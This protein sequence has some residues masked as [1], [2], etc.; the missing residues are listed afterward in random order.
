MDT[1]DHKTHQEGEAPNEEAQKY[2]LFYGRSIKRNR[3]ILM[4][5]HILSVFITGIT[6]HS[7][8]DSTLSTY[9]VDNAFIDLLTVII[10]VAVSLAI[11]RG[12][13]DQW[14]LFFRQ[15]I[16]GY[17]EGTY[18]AMYRSTLIKL[19]FFSALNPLTVFIGSVNVSDQIT[20]EFDGYN[21]RELAAEYREKKEAQDS[22]GQIKV[23]QIEA[24][25][26]RAKSRVESKYNAQIIA[27]EQE[28]ARWD[29]LEKIRNRTYLSLKTKAM[30]KAQAAESEKQAELAEL[31]G[32]MLSKREEV[33]AQVEEA[34]D[35]LEAEFEH[36]DKQLLTA[37]G[38]DESRHNATG[39]AITALTIL[40][41]FF[42][43]AV[44]IS[45]GYELELYYHRTEQELFSQLVKPSSGNGE[46]IFR[47]LQQQVD[48]R[49]YNFG[50]LVESLV[51]DKKD[52]E[53]Y[54]N[55]KTIFGIF[56]GRAARR[57]E[58]A[59]RAIKGLQEL[60][61][62]ERP[63]ESPEGLN[64]G[65]A[66]EHERLKLE[67]EQARQANG[68]SDGR[69]LSRSAQPSATAVERP[70]AV[71]I[72]Y[73]EGKVEKIGTEEYL[74]KNNQAYLVYQSKRKG[75][76]QHLTQEDC[77]KRWGSYG[78]KLSASNDELK[79]AKTVKDEQRI[80]NKIE[81]QMANRQYWDKTYR[82]IQQL[83]KNFAP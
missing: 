77:R 17:T 57:H 7:V 61:A 68:T 26:E 60:I 33:F 12:Y 21:S 52:R 6:V 49:A 54:A 10:A 55:R 30:Q 76:V 22:I 8:I 40:L 39:M 28:L 65:L 42:S 56:K 3:I 15:R 73:Q 13:T 14:H 63:T 38:K 82:T 78:S 53:Y 37:S 81:R 79:A 2:G 27:A 43:W 74:L 16:R 45:L 24:D 4:V 31:D 50:S 48:V 36:I 11:E 44:V 47:A 25:L 62:L 66:A 46:R 41:G 1:T 80:K 67:L 69:L 29:S 20:P 23:A 64:T 59:Q 35:E 18:R 32:T 5:A 70:E 34:K 83:N 9:S 71:G 75:Q 51:P 19:V 72:T 58:E